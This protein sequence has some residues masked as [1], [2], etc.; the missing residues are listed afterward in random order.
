M[1]PISVTLCGF[2]P[3][4]GIKNQVP[5]AVQVSP[6]EALAP[7]NRRHRVRSLQGGSGKSVS[8]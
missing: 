1:A 5:V 2:A 4:R 7:N 3:R 8:L 6:V